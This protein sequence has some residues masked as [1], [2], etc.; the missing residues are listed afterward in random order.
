MKRSSP[1]GSAEEEYVL[2]GRANTTAHGF[3][4]Q[5][6]QPGPAGEHVLVGLASFEPSESDRL[7]HLPSRSRESRPPAGIRRLRQESRPHR[8]ARDTRGKKPAFRLVNSPMHAF[9]IDLRPTLPPFP[10]PTVPDR[11]F[12]PRAVAARIRVR[13]GRRRPSTIHSTPVWW[14]SLSLQRSSFSFHNCVARAAILV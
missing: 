5:F 1:G 11:R 13:S 4:K 9:Q 3:R 2:L 14:R 6:S 10:E 7:S 12:R 8:P